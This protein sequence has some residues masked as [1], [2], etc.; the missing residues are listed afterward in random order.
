MFLLGECLFLLVSNFPSFVL[1]IFGVVPSTRLQQPKAAF[2]KFFFNKNHGSKQEISK[3]ANK[4]FFTY[5]LSNLTESLTVCL[6]NLRFNRVPFS[7]YETDRTMGR[8]KYFVICDAFES[9]IF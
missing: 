9:G 6:R 2:Y 3:Q 4:Q 7:S 1:F 5:A 8:T